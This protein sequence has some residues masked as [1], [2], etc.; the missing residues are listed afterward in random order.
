MSYS[1]IKNYIIYI[2]IF[3]DDQTVNYLVKHFS[4]DHKGI[5]L[6]ECLKW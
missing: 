5:V 1:F 3:L 6:V 2:N 4:R